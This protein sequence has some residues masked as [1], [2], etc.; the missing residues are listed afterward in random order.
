MRSLRKPFLFLVLLQGAL[1]LCALVLKRRYSGQK[2]GVD[3]INA[4]G[5]LGG[6]E[7]ISA[8]KA[9]KGGYIRAF[10][11]GAVV[12]LSDAS[13]DTPP[14]TIEA[15]VILGGAEIRVPEDWTVRIEAQ[16][17]MGGIEDTRTHDTSDDHAPD[18][19]VTGTVA[20]GGLAI[21]D[22]SEKPYHGGEHRQGG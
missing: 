2:L 4:I 14:A 17:T 1:V 6:A 22:Q 15:T 11:G 20:M 7:E 12:D 21:T 3:Q 18:L 19:I 13:I 5:I 9:F 10:M 8:S 16:A